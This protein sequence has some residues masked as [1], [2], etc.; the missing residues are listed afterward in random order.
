MYEKAETKGRQ[1]LLRYR[2]NQ[3]ADYEALHHIH[4]HYNEP[5]P[6]YIYYIGQSK[7][8]EEW[9]DARKGIQG[10]IYRGFEEKSTFTKRT[11]KKSDYDDVSIWKYD[12]IEDIDKQIQ[13]A[14]I[15]KK[16]F[17]AHIEKLRNKLNDIQGNEKIT[18]EQLLKKLAVL[19]S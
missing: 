11:F 4:F 15:T 16:I 10:A 9:Y 1:T 2:A 8:F 17:D 18:K 19:K 7:N 6:K 5:E 14:E 12:D 13:E 3:I